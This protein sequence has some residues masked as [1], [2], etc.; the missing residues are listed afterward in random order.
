M[1]TRR[2]RAT[3]LALPATVALL[4]A[5]P[6]SSA[7]AP[8]RPTDPW[9]AFASQFRD[10]VAADGIVGASALILRNG[11]V[12]SRVDLGQ[13][14]R[15]SNGAVTDRTIYH[16][17]SITKSLTAIA[18]LQLRD[19]GRLSLDDKVT[20]YIPELRRIHDPYGR[21]DSITI[22]MLLSHTAG[23]RNGT[24]P[25]G[26]GSPWQPFEPTSW[27]Q[28]VAMMPYQ[29]LLFPPGARYGYSNPGYIYLGR[30][31]EQLTGDPWDAY[32]QKNIFAPLGMTRS[33]F[34]STPFWLAADRSHN[35][36]IVKDSATGAARLV[37]NGADFDPGITTPNGGWNAP[38]ADLV[39][40]VGFLTGVVPAGGSQARYDVVLSRASLREMWTAVAPMSAGYEAAA[41]QSIGLGFFLQ[42]D[43]EHRVIG[44]TGSQAG[45][46]AFY[47]FNPVTTTGVIA[48]FNTTNYA[49]PAREAYNRMHEAAKALVRDSAR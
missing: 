10:Y 47:Y 4:L 14:D 46:R 35:Y 32:V 23:F 34:R 42:G 48:A 43:G 40:Y 49:A 45:F 9:P 31:V 12:L 7:Q 17:G 33:S 25:Y 26:D 41:G 19:R 6:A 22:R 1:P 5:A 36:E 8:S 27:E 37:D 44:H 13:Q 24:W 2:R 29:T 11:Q 38:L 18:I 15:A 28:L 39:T 16:W 3:P 21:I 30:I 20:R